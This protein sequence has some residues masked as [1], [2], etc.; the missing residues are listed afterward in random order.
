MN[1][2]INRNLFDCIEP[3]K[4][5]K[6]N[7]TEEIHIM[8]D[9]STFIGFGSK[10]GVKAIR[11]LSIIGFTLNFIFLIFQHLRIRRKRTKNNRKNSM[12]QL[13]Q[14]LPLF[15]CITSIYW[16]ISSFY[17]VQAIDIKNNIDFCYG[18]SFFYLICFTFQ[19]TMINCILIHF[20]KINLNPL[21]G[22]LKPNRNVII[23]III[24]IIIGILV[25]LLSIFFNVI[26]KSPMNTCFINTSKNYHNGL[27]F[28]IP[29]IFIILAI[30][31]IIID[32]CCR[33]M[34]ITDKGIRKIYKK[35]SLYV[36]IFCIL[37]IPMI[38]LFLQTIIEEKG[39]AE[40]PDED[41][42][43]YSFSISI[44]TSMIPLIIGL[45]R[46]F[47]GLTKIECFNDLLRKKTITKIRYTRT[48]TNSIR[49]KKDPNDN[50]QNL[51][52]DQDPFE[53]LEN[54]V[55]ECF[56][57]DIL[58]GIA[59][60]LKQSKKYG[61]DISL[62]DV[63]DSMDFE[64]YDINFKTLDK[65]ELNDDYINKSEYLSIKI[66][67]YAPKSFAY[68]R[69]IEN[70]NIDKMIESFLPQNNRQG[71]SKS[72]GKSG[73]FFISTDDNK[74]M[75]K[76]LKSD[77]ID[78]IRNG[79]LKKYINHIDKTNNK[80]LLCRLYGM[81]NIIMAQGDEILIIVMRNVIGD[82]KDNT[83][84]K[85]DL[86]GSTYKR[87]A[88]F[89]VTNLNNKVM[90]DLNFNE[91]EKNIMIGKESI[92]QLRNI[93]SQDSHF[94]CDSELMDYSLFLVKITLN[95]EEAQNIFGK[96]YHKNQNK[97]IKQLFSSQRSSDSNNSNIDN[98]NYIDNN[99]NNI[100]NNNDY[101]DN[102][103]NH[104]NHDDDNNNNDNNDNNENEEIGPLKID[105]IKGRA[106]SRGNL[107]DINH[108]KQYLY[109]SL[110]QGTG[111]IISIIDYFQY[112]NFFKVME[113]N[114]I[115]KFK[116][117][118]K[119]KDNNTI[120]CV[121]PKTY[122][123]RFIKYVYQLTDISQI[124]D[125]SKY[126]EEL[127]EKKEND[128]NNKDIKNNNNAEK[129]IDL[130]GENDNLKEDEVKINIK[131][132]KVN[133]SLRITVMNR[134]KTLITNN[135]RKTKISIER[136]ESNPNEK[137]RSKG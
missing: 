90:K 13:F 86:K 33:G 107:H 102:N 30:I 66:I 36:L 79:F 6:T 38:V 9:C 100:D 99:E 116:T 11:T 121:D 95:R 14:I 132:P 29:I 123:E 3:N 124:L 31:Q 46:Y 75:I 129:E 74:Y 47:Q 73:S 96:N 130:Y 135:N 41:Y 63:G 4:T 53:W 126:Q 49:I 120:S 10:I 64:N 82:L 18:M 105:N 72:Q 48:F 104:Y 59:A 128:I 115:S 87:K 83:V 54:H 117:G 25:G 134:N 40:I 92:N 52:L 16:I 2:T 32:L 98:N 61:N 68:L 76:S 78:L 23:Y 112:F 136:N 80:S 7:T 103:D 35:N 88:D 101:N 127:E 27:F 45:L 69:Q 118:L 67:N 8:D 56:M 71:L 84:V 131:D 108:Y 114:I 89:D 42:V 5:N 26:G 110:N 122:S 12:R 85:F 24:S 34:F 119:K 111:Y 20:R 97:A 44:L 55:M 51:S 137:V 106:S 62:E 19:F 113:A 17:F 65:Y 58:I 22:I 39:G 91:I 94:L 77:E 70:I 28:L 125:G 50:N 81:F 37:H 93:I 21:Q 60:G 1:I 43:L 109:P 57:R 15:D 133:F